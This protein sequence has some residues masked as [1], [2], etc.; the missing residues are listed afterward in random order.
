MLN[1]FFYFFE[2]L[3]HKFNSYGLYA[4]MFTFQICSTNY[5]DNSNRHTMCKTIKIIL[6]LFLNKYSYGVF[7]EDQLR[8]DYFNVNKEIKTVCLC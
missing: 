7:K 2:N 4:K 6:L 8:F 1:I 3:C 5:T